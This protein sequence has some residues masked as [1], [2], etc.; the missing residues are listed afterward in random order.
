MSNNGDTLD[1]SEGF[2][3]QSIA[4][5]EETPRALVP[6]AAEIA[7]IAANINALEVMGMVLVKKMIRES[8]WIIRN[9]WTGKLQMHDDVAKD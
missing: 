4:F 3:V 7:A 6:I 5:R 9:Q 1:F 8:S 2:L